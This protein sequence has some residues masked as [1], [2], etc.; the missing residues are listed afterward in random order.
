MRCWP[1]LQLFGNDQTNH[2]HTPVT[3]NCPMLRLYG[4]GQNDQNHIVVTL[5]LW[6]VTAIQ[7]WAKSPHLQS[8][9][10]WA[11]LPFS[12][13][14][15]PAPLPAALSGSL[16]LEVLAGYSMQTVVRFS[17]CKQ[18]M[19]AKNRYTNSPEKLSLL[20]RFPVLF[21]V[22]IQFVLKLLRLLWMLWE[23]SQNI[24]MIYVSI[25]NCLVSVSWTCAGCQRIFTMA[26]QFQ[27]GATERIENFSKTPNTTKYRGERRGWYT[28]APQRAKGWQTGATC[29]ICQPLFCRFHYQSR[30]Q[31][32]GLTLPSP[33]QR[34]NTLE[35]VLKPSN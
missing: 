22:A 27:Q 32:V 6:S 11:D 33:S 10:S 24:D 34:Y 28:F 2:Y 8:C 25:F 18:A 20:G 9:N 16:P 19:E 7:V 15:L 35:S 12:L 17:K 5:F 31:E 4:I 29:A 26:K 3:R 1:S 30:G 14:E 13:H 23:S 21:Y